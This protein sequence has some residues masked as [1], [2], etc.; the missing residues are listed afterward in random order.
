[1]AVKHARFKPGWLRLAEGDGLSCRPCPDWQG[2]ALRP[3]IA[4]QEDPMPYLAWPVVLLMTGR[5]RGVKDG[6]FS[7]WTSWGRL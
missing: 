7:T 6:N 5:G 3:L 4:R 1:M 2:F